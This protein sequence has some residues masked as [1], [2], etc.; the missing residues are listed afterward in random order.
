MAPPPK[1]RRSNE[2]HIV[3]VDRALQAE[4][5]PSRPASTQRP[6]PVP[7]ASSP[8]TES[9]SSRKHANPVIS[10]TIDNQAVLLGLSD[11]YISAAYSMGAGLSTVD[12]DEAQLDHYH[13][14][15]ATGMGCLETVLK[16]FRTSDARKEARIR[17]RFASLLFEETDNDLEAEECL[18]K[19]ISSCERSRL[20]DLKYA[21]HHLLARV[22]FKAGK[23]KA[24][25]KAVEKL[26]VEV[27][28]LNL[29]HWVYAFRFLR[30]SF[31]FQVQTS[32]GET[33]I[34]VKHLAAVVDTAVS[35]HNSVSAQIV[36]STLSAMIHLRSHSP[37]SVDLAQRDLAAARTH[38]LSQEMGSLPQVRALLDCLNLACSL[39]QGQPEQ[40]SA[41]LQ[42]MQGNLDTASR[43]TSW[44]NEKSWSMPMG[45][46]V[47]VSC[48][49][50][51]DS[52]GVFRLL[53]NGECALNFKWLNQTQIY[54][55]GFLLSGLSAM[56][57]NATNEL[58]AEQF[59]SEGVKLSKQ[60]LP[61]MPQ[62]AA[63]ASAQA[64][65][66]SSI[67]VTMRLYLVFA[68]CGRSAW[69][70]G[71]NGIAAIRRDIL[72]WEHLPDVSTTAL[73]TYLEAVCKHGLADLG[74]ALELYRSPELSLNWEND[75]KMPTGIVNPLKVLAGLNS[76]LVLRTSS[77]NA[78]AADRLLA[79]LEPHCTMRVNGN[80]NEYG[81]RAIEAAFNILKA[82]SSSQTAADGMIIKT[83]QYL[84]LAVRGAKMTLNNQLLC[85]V[86]NMMT[87]LFF[88][89][90]VGEQ[91]EKSAKAGRSLAK[92]SKDKLWTA[93][94]DRMYADT[95]VRCGKSA[96]AQQVRMEGE[97]TMQQLPSA[98]KAVFE[99]R[100][101]NANGA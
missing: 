28:K 52:C 14:L 97:Q 36:A 80:G 40:A 91:A 66:Q 26:V 1:R 53:S 24:A 63:S 98:L 89:N 50:E 29:I 76:I 49:I 65:H 77:A 4:R 60:A 19:G 81:S 32:P 38:Q 44:R 86:M 64:N 22:W 18:S 16:N 71:L 9:T 12:V 75:F 90:I 62:S 42:V 15:L 82:T 99:M 101:V 46:A 55:T 100:G 39:V 69:D 72:N 58:K 92:K 68:F 3:A 94:A 57:T 51:A 88:S 17:L 41:K 70:S 37:D 21:M 95:L 74:A 11:E 33:S 96:D 93:V 30:V 7:V 10:S 35:N 23:T 87:T 43:E 13:S 79:Q 6:K 83:K 47:T 48:D 73:L 78:E 34:M 67:L 85:V 84:Q 2:G 20:P 8:L 5:Q 45:R 54:A 25:M 61:S 27:Q 56:H 59:L 31:G